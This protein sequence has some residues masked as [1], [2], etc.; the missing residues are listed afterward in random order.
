MVVC[1]DADVERA[2]NAAAYYSMNNGGQ[3][4]ISVERCYVEEPVYDEFVRRVTENVRQL[5]QGV[6]T[7]VGTVDIG[8]VTFP[9]QLE[10]VDDHVRD[11]VQKGAKVLV[12]GYPGAGP[13]RFY[14]PTVL[15]DVDHSMKIMRDETFGPT[16]PIM[17]VADVEQGISLANDSQLGLQASVWTRD[18]QRG[19][20]LARRIQAGVVCVNDAQMNYSALNLPMGG[21]KAS[22][23]GTRHGANGIRKYTKVQSLL[24]TRRAP[25]R[26]PHMFPY[27]ARRTLLLR[28]FFRLLYGRGKRD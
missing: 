17:K 16:L 6:P 28:W 10:I 19:E 15:V 7:D 5:R 9:P 2:A 23:L 24:V 1:A 27:R 8:A 4:C 18:V 13:G 20:H 25:K 21:W 3:V 11:A 12:G 26:E 22:G 14:Q